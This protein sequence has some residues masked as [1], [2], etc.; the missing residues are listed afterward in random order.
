M[1]TIRIVQH[2]S[3][4]FRVTSSFG[5][6][7]APIFERAR[8]GRR[9][10][11]QHFVVFVAR[12][13]QLRQRT[14]A[15]FTLP[16]CDDM[17]GIRCILEKDS[18]REKRAWVPRTRIAAS[19]VNA[20]ARQ[21]LRTLVLEQRAPLHV[22]SRCPP[23]LPCS[24]S[25]DDANSAAQESQHNSINAAIVSDDARVAPRKPASPRK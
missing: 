3:K 15:R 11:M 20:H 16:A 23:I 8:A 1:P 10:V 4:P 19:S 21:G 14:N 17:K 18:R 22:L 13:L 5:H 7:V 9:R 12:F 2:N 6:A 24:S 25:A